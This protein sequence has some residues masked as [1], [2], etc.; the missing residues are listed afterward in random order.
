MVEEI[1]HVLKRWEKKYGYIGLSPEELE[2]FSSVKGKRFTLKIMGK[3]LY[4]RKIDNQRRIWVSHG[5]LR[6]LEVGDIL[7]FSRDNKGNYFV[8]KK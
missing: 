4:E 7:V 6:G 5:G 2:F 3:E 8:D 1:E